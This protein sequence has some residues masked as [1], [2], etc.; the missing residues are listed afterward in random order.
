M[1]SIVNLQNLRY[2]S[3]LASQFKLGPISPGHALTI[4]NTLRRTLLC[5]IYGVAIVCAFFPSNHHEYEQAA[6]VQETVS[7]VLFNLKRVSLASQYALFPPQKAVVDFI[8]PGQVLACDIELPCFITVVEP[9]VILAH[10]TEKAHFRVELLLGCGCGGAAPMA[11]QP[12]GALQVYAG[13]LQSLSVPNP[14]RG[15]KPP[16]SSF[17]TFITEPEPSPYMTTYPRAFGFL[18]PTRPLPVKNRQ[19]KAEGLFS[20]RKG[21]EKSLSCR[22]LTGKSR[23]QDEAMRQQRRRF[24]HV[25]SPLSG[26]GPNSKRGL[27]TDM[28]SYEN[29]LTQVQKQNHGESLFRWAYTM[30]RPLWA[31]RAKI[32]PSYLATSTLGYFF[33]SGRFNP[34]VRVNFTIELDPSSKEKQEHIFMEIWSNGSVKPKQAL[35]EAASTT[36]GLFYPFQK[37]QIRKA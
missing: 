1:I 24:D 30:S 34:I 16:K 14:S 21:F 7:D 17:P 28:A 36:M 19:K 25:L 3:L 31:Q 9:D 4:A 35:M 23:L 2:D 12:E 11:D 20:R 13:K 37:E 27:Q 26:R 6:G 10:V 32:R 29:G 8:G 15:Q 18:N 33:V 22:F 5:E